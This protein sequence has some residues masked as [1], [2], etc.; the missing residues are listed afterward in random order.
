MQRATVDTRLEGYL[1]FHHQ[2]FVDFLIEPDRC[3]QMF[4]ITPEQER[5]SLTLACLQTMKR[6]LKFNI[7]QLESSYVRNND[8]PDLA[9]RLK[10]CIPFHLSYSCQFWAKHLEETKFDTEILDCVEYFMSNQFLVWLEVLSLTKRVNLASS[11]L[12]L[13]I[14]W[15]KV[16]FQSFCP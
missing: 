4:L 12:L 10:N 5:R 16:S 3:H 11:I 15:L 6:E 2:S 9:S 1:R 8:I 14:E 7:C 13:L